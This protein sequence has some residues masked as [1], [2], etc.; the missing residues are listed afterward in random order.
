[1]SLVV[2]LRAEDEKDAAAIMNVVRAIEGLRV[3][4]RLSQLTPSATTKGGFQAFLW[5]SAG[6]AHGGCCKS[7]EPAVQLTKGDLRPTLLARV[8][9]SCIRGFAA[10]TQTALLL[11]RQRGLPTQW[12]VSHP[13]HRVRW[14]ACS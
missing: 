13:R 9:R 8:C 4:R 1:M 7:I 10:G 6:S 3:V 5:C 14:L 2:K 12:H 11:P